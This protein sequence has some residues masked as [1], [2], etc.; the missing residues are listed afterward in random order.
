MFQNRVGG[1]LTE[2]TL[3]ALT[4]MSPTDL[5]DSLAH[6]LLLMGLARE[7]FYCCPRRFPEEAARHDTTLAGAPGGATVRGGSLEEG[8][9]PGAP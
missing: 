1:T 2:I 7:L 3:R 8:D 5:T 6:H 4:R 9:R